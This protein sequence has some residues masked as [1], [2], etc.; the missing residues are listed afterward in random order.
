MANDNE[1]YLARILA[2]PAGQQVIIAFI[3]E[4]QTS[5]GNPRQSS[6]RALQVADSYGIRTSLEFGAL[7]D[8]LRFLTKVAPLIP[9]II[10]AIKDWLDKLD[11]NKDY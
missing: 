3:D 11:K 4:W 1:G 7:M 6:D 10:Q 5:G 9:Q 2:T 8:F